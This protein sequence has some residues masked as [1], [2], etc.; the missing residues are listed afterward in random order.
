MRLIFPS[1]RAISFLSALPLLISVSRSLTSSS[2]RWLS[3]PTCL[4]RVFAAR[5]AFSIACRLS[6]ATISI[7]CWYRCFSFTARN[8]GSTSSSSFFKAE[9]CSLRFSLASRCRSLASRYLAKGLA[10]SINLT[11]SLIFSL[12]RILSTSASCIRCRPSRFPSVSWSDTCLAW[13]SLCFWPS[14]FK[15]SCMSII[16]WDPTARWVDL[17]NSTGVMAANSTTLSWGRNWHKLSIWI[18]NDL[19]YS[20]TAFLVEGLPLTENEVLF[21]S[22]LI[23]QVIT[24]FLPFVR[25]LS[26]ASSISITASW[27]PC[28]TNSETS[29][30]RPRCWGHGQ[31]SQRLCHKRRLVPEDPIPDPNILRIQACSFRSHSA[32]W[33][34]SSWVPGRTQPS[35]MWRNWWVWLERSSLVGAPLQKAAP[36]NSPEGAYC[37]NAR[38]IHVKLGSAEETRRHLGWGGL[39]CYWG[40]LPKVQQLDLNQP[41]LLIDSHADDSGMI[42]MKA[43]FRVCSGRKL[44]WYEMSLLR[45][46]S[47]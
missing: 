27:N 40:K 9:A 42:L 41:P 43:F 32:Q 3:A 29:F 45:F 33:P 26:P 34:C 19:A 2:P 36:A 5:S 16:S 6:F 18:E 35:R 47:F 12:S 21:P 11:L 39:F 23:L 20:T 13:I 22:R 10:A 17:S 8:E 44:A 38:Y 14:S 15:F 37:W 28:L 24:K 25:F 31:Y 46:Q 4:S 7:W 1:I 30:A